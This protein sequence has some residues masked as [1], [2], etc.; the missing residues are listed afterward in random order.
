MPGSHLT[1]V[2]AFLVLNFNLFL[3]L[4]LQLDLYAHP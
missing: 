3:F 1:S 2:A 4:S